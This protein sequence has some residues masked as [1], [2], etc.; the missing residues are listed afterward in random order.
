MT[1]ARQKQR[2]ERISQY[3]RRLFPTTELALEYSNAWEL[4]VA[5]VLAAQC[6]DKKVNEVTRTLFEKYP[7]LDDYASASPIEFEAQIKPTGFYRTK[8]KNILKTARVLKAEYNSRVPDTMAELLAL[9][10]VGRKT[11]NIILAKIYRRAEGIPVDTHVRRLARVLTL[12][13]ESD[14]NKIERDLIQIVPKREWLTFPYRLSRYGREICKARP[15][16]HF[17]CPLRGI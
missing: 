15:H 12:T 9:P 4:L 8:A 7:T 16:N 2:A 14:P 1:T 3:L 11:A 17:Q 10:G 13:K 5:L 6:S